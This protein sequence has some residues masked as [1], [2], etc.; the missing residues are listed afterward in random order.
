M[1]TT[2]THVITAHAH[3]EHITWEFDIHLCVHSSLQNTPFCIIKVCIPSFPSCWKSTGWVCQDAAKPS[4]MHMLY[5]RPSFLPCS[6]WGWHSHEPCANTTRKDFD[7]AVRDDVLL[8]PVNLKMHI[9]NRKLHPKFIGSFPVSAKV[10]IV[11]NK[12]DIPS[13]MPIHNTLPCQSLWTLYLP[14]IQKEGWVE[15]VFVFFSPSPSMPFVVDEELAY[16][17]ERILLHNSSVFQRHYYSHWKG[18][19]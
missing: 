2:L 4:L 17:F 5:I 9:Q 8:S 12:L 6:N 16:K 1:D 19:G 15:V 14:N 10:S 3:D 18:Y 13:T 11:A 7:F